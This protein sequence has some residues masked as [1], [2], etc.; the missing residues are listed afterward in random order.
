MLHI[1]PL[2]NRRRPVGKPS[3]KRRKTKQLNAN[4]RIRVSLYK[5]E[6][7]VKDA[8]N[9]SVQ[10]LSI[11]QHALRPFSEIPFE[12]YESPLA[13]TGI[14][15]WDLYLEKLAQM[16]RILKLG[17][18]RIRCEGHVRF[19]NPKGIS[20]IDLA[21]EDLFREKY[22]RE[23]QN[24]D[25]KQVMKQA[26][27]RSLHAAEDVRTVLMKEGVHGDRIEVRAYGNEHKLKANVV[28]VNVLSVD[29]HLSQI[30]EKRVRKRQKF[31]SQFEVSPEGLKLEVMYQW[32]MLLS[33]GPAQDEEQGKRT[34]ALEQDEAQPGACSSRTSRKN[35]TPHSL[36]RLS[37]REV[38]DTAK[39]IA[40]GSVTLDIAREIASGS[41]TRTLEVEEEEDVV[42]IEEDEEAAGWENSMYRIQEIMPESGEDPLSLSLR[43]HADFV[44]FLEQSV[45]PV[46]LRI[47]S[48]AYSVM[49]SIDSVPVAVQENETQD[50]LQDWPALSE[51]QRNEAHT[52]HESQ[53]E[54]ESHFDAAQQ[55]LHHAWSASKETLQSTFRRHGLDC[56][57]RL[58]T[59][60]D[61]IFS[62]F[63]VWY[64]KVC[65]SMTSIGCC[66]QSSTAECPR[67]AAEEI[68]WRFKE[69]EP[70][71][72]NG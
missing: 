68:P 29:G 25:D 2:V 3:N 36:A 69:A 41:A 12:E 43:E 34:G 63:K 61:E 4:T 45:D 71:R 21:L 32:R 11:F 58:I 67:D 8:G 10:H 59:E 51:S 5:L 65:S 50:G 13:R 19:A 48:A 35:R 33:E 18:V 38:L 44:G 39:E 64:G 15:I 1:A 26:L 46:Q 9:D 22:E 27:T 54:T 42:E 47:M 40:S 66:S 31:A 24:V 52:R 17:R 60:Q 6:N 72:R 30:V 7:K 14:K 57:P 49:Q 20:D 53:Y 16:A 70:V 55:Y 23:R 56:E 62:G 28:H 37:S